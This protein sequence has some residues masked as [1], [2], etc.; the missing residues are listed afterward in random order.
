[1]LYKAPLAPREGGREQGLCI[2]L[3]IEWSNLKITIHGAIMSIAEFCFD[4][5][6]HGESLPG[7]FDKADSQC[8][9]S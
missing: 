8:V 1:M 7:A 9:R 2:A 3:K 6:V 5:A 4:L